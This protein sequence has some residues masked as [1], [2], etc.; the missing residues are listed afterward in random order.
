[1]A[2]KKV[3]AARKE[4]GKGGKKKSRKGAR[5]ARPKSPLHAAS[6]AAVKRA[7]IE[8]L[9]WVHG[10]LVASLDSVP[11]S[12]ATFQ[13][14]PSDN[15][16]HWTYGHLVTAYLWFASLIDGKSTAAPANYDKLF[17]MKST[18]QPDAG[19]YPALAEVKREC[20]AAYKRFA[21]AVAAMK[22][23]DMN[24]PTMAESHGFAKSRLDV[25]YK[26]AWHDGW[27]NGQIS[28][29]RRAL[30]LPPMM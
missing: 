7:A 13:A 27:H 30:G 6:P 10:M 17:G 26:A 25:V 12:K 16:A 18:P 8:Y 21:D 19:A 3:H 2:K 24:K 28:T 29:V 9:E 4:V 22:P 1:M 5:R 11:E 20:A 14:S 15:H 23:A